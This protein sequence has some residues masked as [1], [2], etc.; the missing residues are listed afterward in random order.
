MSKRRILWGLS[1][2][3][4]ILFVSWYTDFGGPLTDDEIATYMERLQREGSVTGDRDLEDIEN[5]MREDSGRQFF[6]AN[7]LDL[8]DNPPDVEGAEPG[9]SASQLMDRYMAYIWPALLSR[10]SHPTIGG[11]AINSAMDLEGIEGAESW[12]SA[13]LIR[14]RSRRTLMDIVTNPEMGPSHKYKIAALEKTIAFPIET[15]INLGDPRVLL[16]LLLLAITALID[17]FLLRRTP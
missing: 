13:A 10:A 14:Y 16:G 9:E 17:N 11:A 4:Y 6:M 12:D 7:F 15:F 2:L 3:L 5:F 8:R 1:A